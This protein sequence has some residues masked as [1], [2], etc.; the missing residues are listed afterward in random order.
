LQFLRRRPEVA[1][2]RQ[3]AGELRE[4][5]PDLIVRHEDLA[6]R[7]HE[8]HAHTR[9]LQRVDQPAFG[10]Q[11]ARGLALHH[12]ADIVLHD[13]HRIEQDSG[14]VS[15]A[16]RDR[17]LQFARRNAVGHGRRGGQGPHDA[18]GQKRRDDDGQ[19]QRQ[20]RHRDAQIFVIADRP[21]RLS[22]R[23]EAVIGVQFDQH[24]EAVE[25]PGVERIELR[26]GRLRGIGQPDRVP[27]FHQRGDFAR[28]LR[29][30]GKIGTL[31][32]HVKIAEKGGDQVV[33]L[34]VDG[35]PLACGREAAAQ[36]G[37]LHLAEID[38]GR[39]GVV[40]RHQRAVIGAHDDIAG[41]IENAVAVC[42]Q[43]AHDHAQREERAKDF[44][45][46][47]IGFDQR[48]HCVFRLRQERSSGPEWGGLG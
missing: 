34:P 5:C 38:A 22:A 15:P 37:V 35:R 9:R 3:T 41:R 16:L 29:L 27:A 20:D 13:R 17:R 2:G 45:A 1:P 48:P 25:N 46:D 11:R 6:F 23:D 19:Q 47:R 30:I 40:D 39:A 24:V 14:F 43:R 21:H 32:R 12:F 7:V 31:L 28:D 26:A 10:R 18:A 4:E 36:H 33:D 44:R 8:H 42:A